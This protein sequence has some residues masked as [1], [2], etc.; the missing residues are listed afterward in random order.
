MMILL[1]IFGGIFLYLLGGFVTVTL[2]SKYKLIYPS[3]ASKTFWWWLVAIIMTIISG[4][5]DTSS[6]LLYQYS[7]HLQEKS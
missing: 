7:M 6:E 1:Y 4:I 3:E 5:I 2:T